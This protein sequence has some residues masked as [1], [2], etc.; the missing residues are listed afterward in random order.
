L[1][2]IDVLI[3]LLEA[4]GGALVQLMTWWFTP[5]MAII[6]TRN[7]TN[8]FDWLRRFSA[9]VVSLVETTMARQTKLSVIVPT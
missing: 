3:S 4:I 8:N 1:V 2:H 6:F 5:V 7:S 9:K